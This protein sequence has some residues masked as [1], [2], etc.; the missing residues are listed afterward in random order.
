MVI[1]VSREALGNTNAR[2]VIAP[3]TAFPSALEERVGGEEEEEKK[4]RKEAKG[5]RERMERWR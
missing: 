1:V 5:G 2:N 3:N 4:R